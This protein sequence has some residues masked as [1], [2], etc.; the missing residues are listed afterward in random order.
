VSGQEETERLKGKTLF[1][2]EERMELIE[3]CK[4]VDDIICP[5]PWQLTTEF[6]DINNIDYVAHDV[7]YFY[8]FRKRNINNIKNI[9]Y[10]IFGIRY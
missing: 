4:W 1:S 2:E 10:T 3:Y 5:C 8:I 7:I 9:G 6:L